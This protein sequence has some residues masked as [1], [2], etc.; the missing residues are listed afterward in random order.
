LTERGV[1][2]RAI[3]SQWKGEDDTDPVEVAGEEISA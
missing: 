2:A 1:D 3:A